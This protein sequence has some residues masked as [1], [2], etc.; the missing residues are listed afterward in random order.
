MFASVGSDGLVRL[1]DV[2]S[3]NKNITTF[4]AHDFEIMSCDFNKYEE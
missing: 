3:P 1:W 4:K 2:T